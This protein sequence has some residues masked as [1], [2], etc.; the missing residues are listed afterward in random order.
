MLLSSAIYK[1]CGVY[2]FCCSKLYANGVNIYCTMSCLLFL[3][4]FFVNAPRIVLSVGG[5]DLQPFCE[6][7]FIYKCTWFRKF[8]DCRRSIIIL[9]SFLVLFIIY[10]VFVCSKCKVVGVCGYFTRV[11]GCL[12]RNICMLPLTI[13]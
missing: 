4:S 8:Y 2:L 12:H 10:L 6:H 13:P 3:L 5:V 1:L 9:F 7:S 11:K